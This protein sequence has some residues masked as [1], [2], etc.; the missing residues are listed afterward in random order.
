[1][2]LP[3][4]PSHERLRVRYKNSVGSKPPGKIPS[5]SLGSA[6]LHDVSKKVSCQRNPTRRTNHN[7]KTNNNPLETEKR[8]ILTKYTASGQP[9]LGHRQ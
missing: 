9:I 5:L 3:F 7:N 1:M 2:P 8:Q 4:I 6:Y